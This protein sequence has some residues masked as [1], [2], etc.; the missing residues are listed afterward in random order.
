M[1]LMHRKKER[2]VQEALSKALAVN[3][4]PAF[5][6]LIALLL[7]G[8]LRSRCRVVM[9]NAEDFFVLLIPVRPF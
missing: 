8:V 5:L 6:D 9:S 7:S 3:H 2:S 4:P 1:H